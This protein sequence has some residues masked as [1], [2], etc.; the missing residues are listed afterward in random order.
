MKKTTTGIDLVVDIGGTNTR[1]SLARNGVLDVSTNARFLNAGRDDLA[2]ILT[3]YLGAHKDRDID[4]ICV[5]LAGPIK[6]SIGTLTNLSWII[7]PQDLIDQTNAKEAHI[8]NDLQAQGYGLAGLQD[9]AL[10]P[11]IDAPTADSGSTKLVLNVGTG[12]N[13]ASVITTSNDV[14]VAAAESGHIG[15][16]VRDS[17]DLDLSNYVKSAHGFA[18]VE[19]VLSGRGL[20]R[21]YTWRSGGIEKSAVDLMNEAEKGDAIALQT[22]ES[23]IRV[24]GAVAG[25]LTLIHLPYGGVY[26]VG[27]VARAMKHYFE[28]MGFRDNF[29]DKGRFATF[30][31]DFS[32]QSVEDDNAAMIGCA[33]FLQNS[34]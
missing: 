11:I 28:R 27:G 5:A 32:V 10:A 23:F 22:V 6:D 20:E 7:R 16:P 15:L 8:I 13:C 34:R 24:L 29:R 18:A 33:Q 12:F 21:V 26:F 30:M 25:D 9:E 19:D 4:G 1:C 31:D 17:Q 14:H 3:E 2:G